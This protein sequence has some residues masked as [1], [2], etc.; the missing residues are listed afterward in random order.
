VTPIPKGTH[1]RASLDQDGAF[2]LS[3]SDAEFRWLRSWSLRGGG[4]DTL[5]EPEQDP[6][7]L[8][9]LVRDRQRLDGVLDPRGNVDGHLPAG[10]HRVRPVDR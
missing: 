5:I 10:L 6:A 2:Y 9:E 3:F 4:T 8:T 7:S 1:W